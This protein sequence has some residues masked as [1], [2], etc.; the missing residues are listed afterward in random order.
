MKYLLTVVGIAFLVAFL[1]VL[2]GLPPA[3]SAILIVALLFGGVALAMR[4]MK[5]GGQDNNKTQ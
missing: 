1:V 2:T 4:F 5:V 3:I